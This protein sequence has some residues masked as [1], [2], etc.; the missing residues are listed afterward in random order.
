MRPE[1]YL[2][3]LRRRKWVIVF[4][5][6]LVLFGATV[7][8]VLTPDLYR[9]SMKILIIPPAVSEGMVRS[10]ADAASGDRLKILQQ[11]IFGSASLLNVI[12]ELGLFPER[13]GALTGDAMVAEMRKRIDMEVDRNNTFTLSFDHEDP[14]TAQNVASRLGSF[15]IGENIRSRSATVQETSR[16]L[17]GQVQETRKRL[18]EQEERIKRYKLRFG[19]ELPQQMQANLSQL[20]RLQDQIKNNTD[21]IARLED[22]K[23]FLEAQ[24]RN[25]E[26]QVPAAGIDAGETGTRGSSGEV[27]YLL[28]ELAVRRK[29]LDELNSKYTPL[30]P[31]VVQARWEVEKLE[32]RI[33]VVRM[34]AAKGGKDSAGGTREAVSPEVLA[35]IQRA[36]R[37]KREVDRLRDQVASI[38]L[39]ITALKRENAGTLRNIDTIQRQVERLPQREQEI[40]ALT[41]DYDNIKRS[42]EELLKKR[43]DANISETLEVKQKG[44]RFQVIDPANL[45]S[46][47]I[48]PDRLKL[49]GLSFLASLAIGIGGAFVLETLD[50]TLRGARDFRNFFDLPV[51]ASLPLIQDERYRRQAAIRRAA[52][53]GGL[54]SIAGAYVVFLLVYSEKV[55]SILQSIGGVN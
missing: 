20:A 19:G 14:R 18:E 38:A 53:T 42:Y 41:R 12:K 52:V 13:S 32:A 50:P 54:V 46:R 3:M 24:I 23:I 10:T 31:S 2:D 22:R 30:H 35:E 34:Q 5:V 44:E 48:K 49:L 33:E 40:I 4:S 27:D 28:A 15:F 26:G 43:L 21:S 51:L 7:F 37:M 6:L 39:D 36:N 17:E 11:D 29:K 25:V 47:P 9:S 8:C 1:E 55:K 45:P 16:F